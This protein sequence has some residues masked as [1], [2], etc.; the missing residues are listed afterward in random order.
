MQ[1]VCL[2][3][4]RYSGLTGRGQI[5]ILHSS[6]RTESGQKEAFTSEGGGT[7]NSTQKEEQ[8]QNRNEGEHDPLVCDV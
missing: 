1:D 5:Q 6:A 4:P 8:V 2:R 3:S 7:R